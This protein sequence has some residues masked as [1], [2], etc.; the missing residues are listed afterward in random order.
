MFGKVKDR[1]QVQM[2]RAVM[3]A[4]DRMVGFHNRQMRE[5]LGLNTGEFDMIAALGNTSGMRMKDLAQAMITS[6][7][8][9]TRVATAMEKRGL[10]ERSRSAESQR[11]VLARLTPEGE[12]MFE[13]T[14]MRVADFTTES[15]NRGLTPE[16]QIQVVE[17]LQRF[18]RNLDEAGLPEL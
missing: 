17:L 6:P 3:R 7:A 13:T 2:F 1:S 9:V 18:M 16:E 5:K 12:R 10:V 4:S 11:E 14:F 8:N 15:T